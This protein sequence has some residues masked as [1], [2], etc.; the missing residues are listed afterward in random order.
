MI[1]LGSI[2]FSWFLLV[3]LGFS[4]FCS[5]FFLDFFVLGILF[6]GIDVLWDC[7]LGRFVMFVFFVFL[8]GHYGA[9]LHASFRDHVSIFLVFWKGFIGGEHHPHLKYP[10]G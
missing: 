7:F 3:F 1:F 4:G 2:G 6:F 8:F 5:G 9:L 10:L